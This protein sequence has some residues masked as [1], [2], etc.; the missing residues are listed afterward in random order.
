LK[1][2][3]ARAVRAAAITGAVALLLAACE[4]PD[5][6]DHLWGHEPAAT[7]ALVRSLPLPGAFGA[8]TL[9]ADSSGLLWI[10]TGGGVRVLDPAGGAM[11]REIAL[12]TGAAPR[13]A[14]SLGGHFYLL[15]DSDLFRVDPAGT[16]RTQRAL[17]GGV[18]AL[19][20][21]GR[22]LYHGTT[23]GTVVGLD[24]QQLRPRW[25]WTRMGAVTTALASSPE[26]DRLYQALAPD[27]A[28]GTARL[29][30]RDL[31]T[32]R[33][34]HEHEVTGEV[35][36]LEVSGTG[37]L[38]AVVAGPDD[39]EVLC[40]RPTTEGLEVIW[41][42]DVDGSPRDGARPRLESA[43]RRLIFH[44]GAHGKFALLDASNGHRL[45]EADEPPL[46]AAF[47]ADGKIYLLYAG[48]VRVLR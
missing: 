20:P 28:S 16:V 32:G 10:G 41:R 43:G 40:M 11:V 33:I 5:N 48:E 15:T 38:Y 25:A 24:T 47:G 12:E 39:A 19:D 31:Q 37:W 34:M 22:Y 21:L 42:H 13:L 4:R 6:D 23:A 1:W 14:G 18:A 26:G 9:G 44:D 30:V 29:L 3:S 36:A 35:A 7:P 8:A 17:G 45:M 46:D 27:P 2:D